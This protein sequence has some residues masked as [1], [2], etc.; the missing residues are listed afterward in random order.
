MKKAKCEP[1]P[2]GSGL[3]LDECCQRYLNGT[4]HPAT[5][6]ALMR[7]RY[8]AYALEVEQYLLD[9]WHPS[10]RPDTLQLNAGEAAK[11]VG[12]KIVDTRAGGPDDTRGVVEFVA[13]YKVR[14]KAERLQERSRFVREDGR[15]YYLDAEPPEPAG[16]SAR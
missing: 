3:C 7:S 11:W 8:S 4:A 13:R 5:A 2:C 1:C 14:G 12:L 9:T 6:E 15:W 10:T 16:E